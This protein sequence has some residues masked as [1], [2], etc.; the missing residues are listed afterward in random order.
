MSPNPPAEANDRGILPPGPDNL[1]GWTTSTTDPDTDEFGE[2]GKLLVRCMPPAFR[3]LVEVYRVLE[4]QDRGSLAVLFVD[5]STPD[6]RSLL[7]SAPLEAVKV[8]PPDWIRRYQDEYLGLVVCYLGAGTTR[9]DWDIPSTSLI[10]VVDWPECSDAALVSDWYVRLPGVLTDNPN[11][12]FGCV[13]KGEDDV[14]DL[15]D[16]IRIILHK[17][18]TET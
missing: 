11:R 3:Q 14:R 15:L 8:N 5:D 6:G 17:G 13:V 10:F 7:K 1:V 4:T 12:A 16:E 2:R 18:E 9:T